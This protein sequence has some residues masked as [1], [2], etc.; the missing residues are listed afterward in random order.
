MR[1]FF[2][3]ICLASI[4]F[5]SLPNVSIAQNN[6]TQELAIQASKSKY[7][8]QAGDVLEIST[9]KEPELSREEVIVRMDG[10]ISFPLINDIQAANLSP[11]QL[12]KSIEKRLKEYVENPVVTVSVKIFNSQ[13]FY[14]LGEILN[15]G[16]YP[17][18]KKLTVLQAFAMAGGFT[19]WA[20]KKEIIL[21]R[22]ENGEDKVYRI[23]YRN[24]MKGKD[25]SSNILLKADDTIIVP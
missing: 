9:W 16:E 17:I 14:I 24:I 21:L 5:L 23:N 12:K 1:S 11:I 2:S 25:Y 20:Q 7:Q 18:N 3:F 6:S 10:K 4:T 13:K 15:T 8:I 22:K 19:E